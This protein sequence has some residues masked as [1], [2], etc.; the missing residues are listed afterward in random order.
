MQLHLNS[1]GAYLHVK[2]AMFDIRKKQP[3]G[4]WASA[5]GV[6]AHKVKSIWLGPGTAL[7]SDAV[8]LAL[9]NNIDIVFLENS[10]QPLGRVWHSKLG[11]T[12]RIRRCQLEASL[13]GRAMAWTRTWLA[14]K[15][16]IKPTLSAT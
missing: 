15:L 10:G 4:S 8:S 1:Y 12:T 13:D 3:D 11:S 6:A 5:S 2:D 14:Q 7:S 16:E 9:R